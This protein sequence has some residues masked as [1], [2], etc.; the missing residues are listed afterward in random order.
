MEQPRQPQVTQQRR[1]KTRQT[2]RQSGSL[3]CLESENVTKQCI[4]KFFCL[5]KCNIELSILENRH[6]FLTKFILQSANHFLI[7]NCSL[8]C[9][10]FLTWFGH[11]P[12][13]KFCLSP[14]TNCD[15]DMISQMRRSLFVVTRY[16]LAKRLYLGPSAIITTC[17]W[18][19][20]DLA[21]VALLFSVLHRAVTRANQLETVVH[22]CILI[23]GLVS[24]M[25]LSF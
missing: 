23:L 8:F 9:C 16:D 6:F 17:I 2:V 10:S 4:V 14:L 20:T 11:V 13:G 18:Y 24:V 21:L 7:N 15:S 19:A 22:G 5:P 1:P 12:E 3:R 25:S